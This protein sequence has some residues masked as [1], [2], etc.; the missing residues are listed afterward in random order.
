MIT[1]LPDPNFAKT[2]SILDNKRL[3][4]QR[5]EALTLVRNLVGEQ[6][7]W[8]NHPACKMWRGYAGAVI[9]Y[10]FYICREIRNR[11]YTSE[12]ANPLPFVVIL[13]ETHQNFVA[14]PWWFDRE[15]KE[16]LDKV[17]ASHRSNLLRKDPE[18]Y[19]KY[20]WSEPDN[21]PYFW[22]IVGQPQQEE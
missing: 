19:G 10:G 17:C 7:G 6:T 18:F 21:L 4:N 14:L 9:Q 22:P 15:S 8:K 11:G 12:I 2:A 20:G 16:Y 1:F 13:I 5:N 3:L